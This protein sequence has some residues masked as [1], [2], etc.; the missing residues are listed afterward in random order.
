[1]AYVAP[2]L[3]GGRDAKSPIEGLGAEN[4][5]AAVKLT[6]RK[7]TELGD[8]LLIEYDVMR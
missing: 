2:M 7:V 3:M 8:D 5:D 6:N 1:M 4:P